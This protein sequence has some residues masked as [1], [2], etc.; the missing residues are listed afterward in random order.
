MC[1]RKTAGA[2][3]VAR[4]AP[5]PAHAAIRKKAGT[6][7]AVSFSQYWKAWTKVTERIPP[8]ATATVTTNATTSPPTQCGAPVR[9]PSVS[10]APCNCGSRYS[11]PTPS[12][13][14]TAI[15]RTTSD[16][17]RACAKSGSVYAPE[18]RSGAAT[19]TSSTTYPA[20]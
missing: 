1:S 11:Q 7:R 10:P 5:S 20:V 16:S 12:T 3:K 15:R 2:S 13:N 6:S 19:S 4:G 17:S 8:H 18:R 9:I 14:S